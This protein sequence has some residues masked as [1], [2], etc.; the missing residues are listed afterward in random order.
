[1]ENRPFEKGG[2][3]ERKMKNVLLSSQED[4]ASILTS[5]TSYVKGTTDCFLMILVYRSDMYEIWR[6]NESF[7]KR[8]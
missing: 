2:S 4:R 1:M 7:K 3:T 5:I 6:L 8:L